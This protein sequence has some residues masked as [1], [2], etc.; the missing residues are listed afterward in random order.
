MERAN[1]CQTCKKTCTQCVTYVFQLGFRFAY[2]HWWLGSTV[3]V[4]QVNEMKES[5]PNRL[6][7][8]AQRES[9][10]KFWQLFELGTV[11]FTRTRKCKVQ[12]ASSPKS[13]QNSNVD[14]PCAR[15]E[16][17]FLATFLCVVDLSD[18]KVNCSMVIFPTKK[19][20]D[21]VH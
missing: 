8:L 19:K 7:F 15:E 18:L 9:T 21:V 20:M 17:S 11:F 4:R 1:R 2:H 16:K 13:C 10:H 6:F 3:D 5:C 14:S 12:K